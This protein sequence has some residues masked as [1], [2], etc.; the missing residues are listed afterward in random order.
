MGILGYFALILV[1][2]ILAVIG[3]GGSILTV[4]ILV[5]IFGLAADLS[6]SYSLFLVGISAAVGASQYAKQNLIA[7]RIGTIFTVPAFVGVFAVRKFLMPIIPLEFELLSFNITKDKLILSVFA[8][9]ML[10]AAISMIR[11]RQEDEQN[12]ASDKPLNFWLIGL[13]GLVVG[14][15][16]GFVGAGGGFLI[17]PA[18]V[19]LA[20]L[21]MKE[22]V[23]TSLMIIAIK[24]LFGFTGDLGTLSIDWG[25]LLK[26][27]GMSIIGIS[28]GNYLA[29]YIKSETLK[30][31]FGYFVLCMGTFIIIQQ[32]LS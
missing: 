26:I 1:G 22:A 16:T 5:Y 6:T 24:S 3:G 21:P 15:V 31:F 20:G 9:I 23:G 29:K 28:I 13:E 12:S 18:L 4:P 7:Y 10:V 19:L 27:S 8:L 25:F 2:M 32:I 11:G 14:A 17:I 30:P